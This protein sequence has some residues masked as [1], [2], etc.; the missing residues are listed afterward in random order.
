MYIFLIIATSHFTSPNSNYYCILF[1]AVA[2][3]QSH[4]LAS[5]QRSCYTHAYSARVAVAFEGESTVERS[6][7]LAS[8]IGVK[9]SSDSSNERKDGGGGGE[10]SRQVN[11]RHRQPPPP[12]HRHVLRQESSA[13]ASRQAGRQ[14]GKLFW[15]MKKARLLNYLYGT[16]ELGISRCWKK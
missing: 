6:H 7:W 1:P 16:F 13:R 2:W 9:V 4:L 15:W 10:L 14:A 12:G 8:L 5:C 11:H 3:Y